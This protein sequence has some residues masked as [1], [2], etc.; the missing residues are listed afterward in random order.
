M[1]CNAESL[2][3]VENVCTGLCENGKN[4]ILDVEWVS[5]SNIYSYLAYMNNNTSLY[6]TPLERALLTCVLTLIGG[7]LLFPPTLH[8]SHLMKYILTK[9]FCIVKVILSQFV[10]SDIAEKHLINGSTLLEGL[11]M[12]ALGENRLVCVHAC[13]RETMCVVCTH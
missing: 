3:T 1:K 12:V 4:A 5:I 8:H 11:C 10:G 7:Y 2:T 13:M 6:H 9:H